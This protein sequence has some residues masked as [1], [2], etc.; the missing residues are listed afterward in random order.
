MPFSGPG[1]RFIGE[2]DFKTVLS[3]LG[4]LGFLVT[5]GRVVEPP[6]YGREGFY[7]GFEGD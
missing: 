1:A 7:A 5:S 4:L 3:F 6:G 2:S